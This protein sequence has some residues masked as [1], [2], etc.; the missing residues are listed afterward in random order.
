M[1]AATARNTQAKNRREPYKFRIVRAWP[2]KL[3]SIAS[4]HHGDDGPSDNFKEVVRE[5]HQREAISLGYRALPGTFWT[6]VSQ[7]QMRMEIGQLGKLHSCWQSIIGRSTKF[8]P[9]RAGTGKNR[10]LARTTQTARHAIKK[11]G[12]S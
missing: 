9:V 7:R 1:Y 2:E 6:Q 3:T 10:N 12:S 4:R 8:I 5:G 11:V